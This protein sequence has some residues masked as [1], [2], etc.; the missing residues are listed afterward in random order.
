MLSA[1]GGAENVNSA[2]HCATRL[3]L[4]LKDESKV[5]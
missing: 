1:I 4:V 2:A 3:R 5:D